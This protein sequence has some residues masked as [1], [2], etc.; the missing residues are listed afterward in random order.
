MSKVKEIKLLRTATQDDFQHNWHACFQFLT[1]SQLLNTNCFQHA[2][3]DKHSSG[4]WYLLLT[5]IL[6]TLQQT[7]PISRKYSIK[8]ICQVKWNGWWTL[9]WQKTCATQRSASAK[10]TWSSMAEV[11]VTAKAHVFLNQIA[12]IYLH[13]T[14]FGF[15]TRNTE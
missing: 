4:S 5:H 9:Q 12:L 2:T 7:P 3:N 14:E 6:F 11:T 8:D 13:K 15:K 1:Q 10:R